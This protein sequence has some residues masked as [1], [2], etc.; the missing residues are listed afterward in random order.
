MKGYHF[1][2]AV[3][4]Y[5]FCGF[6]SVIEAFQMCSFLSVFIFEVEYGGQVFCL[7]RFARWSVRALQYKIKRFKTDI[8]LIK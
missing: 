4:Q 2:S 7:I 5:Y 3:I 8:T 1:V 6:I